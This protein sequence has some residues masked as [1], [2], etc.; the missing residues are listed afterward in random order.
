MRRVESSQGECR[1][2]DVDPCY[3]RF[4]SG[5]Q[6]GEEEERDAACAGAEVEDADLC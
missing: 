2:R 5:R 3:S 4:E 1:G 6:E